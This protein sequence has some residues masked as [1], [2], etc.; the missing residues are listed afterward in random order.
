MVDRLNRTDSSI[1]VCRSK[2]QVRKILFI[3]LIISATIY[4]LFIANYIDYILVKYITGIGTRTVF[5]P[6][7]TA[8]VVR[9]YRIIN[10]NH[11]GLLQVDF[12]RLFQQMHTSVDITTTNDDR[13]ML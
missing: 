11:S 8:F 10:L 13:T 4:G 2:R 12:S 5:R 9:L 3:P 1:I 6:L 7:P